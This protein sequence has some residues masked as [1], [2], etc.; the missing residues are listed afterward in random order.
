MTQTE[1]QNLDFEQHD[2]IFGPNPVVAFIQMPELPEVSK[3]RNSQRDIRTKYLSFSVSPDKIVGLQFFLMGEFFLL[4]KQKRN[5]CVFMYVCVLFLF[6]FYDDP[7]QSC[8][9]RGL[10]L[11]CRSV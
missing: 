2:T 10:S 9:A 5:S 6:I 3:L 1:I 7:M 4:E 11:L 8:F